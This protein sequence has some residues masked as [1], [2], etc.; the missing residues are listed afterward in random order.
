[1]IAVKGVK[2]TPTTIEKI[3]PYKLIEYAPFY[4]VNVTLIIRNIFMV[5][6]LIRVSFLANFLAIKPDLLGNEK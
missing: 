2:M 3:Q 4:Y 5:A 6:S 1:L